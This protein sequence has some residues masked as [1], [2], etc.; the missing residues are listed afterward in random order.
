MTE[1]NYTWTQTLTDVTLSLPVDANLRGKDFDVKFT[2]NH[3]Q[4]KLKSSPS[5]L[6]DVRPFF[7]FFQ[8][9]TTH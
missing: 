4:I 1:E 9:H 3:L 5:F 2:K 7:F 6:V 8:D